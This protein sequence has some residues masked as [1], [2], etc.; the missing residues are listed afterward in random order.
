MCRIVKSEFTTLNCEV[1]NSYP[2]SVILILGPF[3]KG[4]CSNP[5]TYFSLKFYVWEW[6]LHFSQF[7]ERDV[8]F[9]KEVYF[10]FWF[11]ATKYPSEEL[12]TCAR[13]GHHAALC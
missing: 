4:D 5:A 1:Q 8:E 11:Y 10:L 3:V 6:R 9:I 2:P 7:T 13:G 12:M